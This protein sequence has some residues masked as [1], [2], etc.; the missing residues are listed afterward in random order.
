MAAV[1]DITTGLE[2]RQEDVTEGLEI[3]ISDSSDTETIILSDEEIP[4]RD[5]IT[6]TDSDEVS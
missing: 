6:I 5:V 1:E 2:L 3:W 4:D